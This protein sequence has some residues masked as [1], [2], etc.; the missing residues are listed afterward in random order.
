MKSSGDYKK[1]GKNIIKN[2]SNKNL[3]EEIINKAFQ[4]HSEGKIHEAAKY[5][6]K[7][8]NEGYYDYRVFNNCVSY[9]IFFDGF[10]MWENY[11]TIFKYIKFCH[12]YI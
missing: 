7:L 5:Y 1:S 6:Q 9:V 3:N 4:F 2:S 12:V 10:L 11:L 8:I